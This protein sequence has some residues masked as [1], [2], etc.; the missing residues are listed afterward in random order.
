MKDSPVYSP[1][2]GPT[3]RD[4]KPFG[5]ANERNGVP[6]LPV[7]GMQQNPEQ[8]LRQNGVFDAKPHSVYGIIQKK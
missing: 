4:R 5:Q 3:F 8:R 7:T 2:T 1:V 6:I